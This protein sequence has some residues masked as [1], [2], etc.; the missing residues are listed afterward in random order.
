MPFVQV[1]INEEIE[2]HCNESPSLKKAWEESRG[3]YKLTLIPE[4]FLV[5]INCPCVGLSP[6]TVP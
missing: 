2:K 6:D 1:N 4:S 3:E 5:Y